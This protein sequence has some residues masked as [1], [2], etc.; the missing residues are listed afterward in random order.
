VFTGIIE[1]LGKIKK[2][3]V[4]GANRIFTISASFS[5][6]LNPKES[7]AVNGCCLTVIETKDAEFT[8]EAISKTLA[9]TN[10][11]TLRVGDFVNLE[12]ALKVSSRFDGHWILGHIDEI[13]KLTRL[14]KKIGYYEIKISNIKNPVWLIRKGSVAVDGISL[15]IA[16][17]TTDGFL[18]N[19]I[20]FTYEHTNLKHRRI[21]DLI[22]IEYDIIG[23][24][25]SKLLKGC[26][27]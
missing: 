7:I 27:Q 26:G 17:L 21:G 22:N 20:P 8:V 14:E 6:E 18:I 3:G 19:I 16:D 24:Y 2:I 23:K 5:R 12:R 10:L 15:T 1:E 11:K 9:E 4:R 13:G 25:V